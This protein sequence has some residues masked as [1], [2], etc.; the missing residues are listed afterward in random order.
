MRAVENKPL[1]VLSHALAVNSPMSP[2]E[3]KPLDLVCTACEA[4]LVRN[5]RFS[6]EMVSDQTC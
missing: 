6:D 4:L 5:K 1:Y 3:L 2:S